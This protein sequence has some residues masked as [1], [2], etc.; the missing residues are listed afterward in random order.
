[1][2]RL[3]ECCRGRFRVQL[4]W[5]GWARPTLSECRALGL[6]RHQRA[7]IREVHLMCD[8]SPRV[9]ARTV[10]PRASL[11]GRE[12]RLVRLGEQPL[13]AVLFAD[14]H[15]CR[16]EVEIARIEPGTALHAHAL[17]DAGPDDNAIWGRRSVFWLGRKPL[18]VSEIFLNPSGWT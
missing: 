16:G 1:T 18:L 13:G 8:D 12:R 14:P 11:R 2:R 4:D 15:M 6:R 9:F 17:G 3:Q 7:L 10:I 5:Q